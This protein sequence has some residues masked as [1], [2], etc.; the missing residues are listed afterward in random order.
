[1][2]TLT[3]TEAA[4]IDLEKQKAAHMAR[5][6]NFDPSAQQ[7]EPGDMRLTADY[8]EAL[9]RPV[10]LE[11]DFRDPIHVREQIEVLM[12]ALSDAKALT[13]QHELGINRQRIR[14]RSVIKDAAD[15]LTIINGRTPAGRRRR[16]MQG[17]QD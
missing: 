5:A 16:A 4:I 9:T 15:A 3:V 8:V 10:R 1:M 2:S 6:K 11:L 17:K 12:G 14:L 13:Q 7:Q